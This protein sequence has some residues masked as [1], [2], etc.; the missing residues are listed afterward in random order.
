MFELNAII[1][2]FIIAM[3]ITTVAVIA[4]LLVEVVRRYIREHRT[5]QN[6]NAKPTIMVEKLKNGNYCVA[7]GFLEGDT[8]IVDCKVWEAKELDEELQKFP[9]GQPILVAS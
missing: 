7:T 4:R 1:Q 8:N 5:K 6:V 3:A 9:V 2:M